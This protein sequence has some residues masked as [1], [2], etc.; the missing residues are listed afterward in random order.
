MGGKKKNVKKSE[1]TNVQ[2][3]T[4]RTSQSWQSVSIDHIWSRRLTQIADQMNLN[5]PIHFIPIAKRTHCK[6]SLPGYS[7]FQET[8]HSPPSPLPKEGIK[9][10]Q[11]PTAVRWHPCAPAWSAHGVQQ[12]LVWSRQ[13]RHRLVL[14]SVASHVHPQVGVS[15]E[16]CTA[17]GRERGGC[18]SWRE[19]EVWRV[20]GNEEGAAAVNNIY[21]RLPCLFLSHVR[22]YML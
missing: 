2:V 6:A 20:K 5:L 9:Q 17:G 15:L 1:G 4:I 10:T 3:P 11:P 12:C 7:N 18:V 19:R 16:T 13:R 14:V 22:Y 8:S 21:I